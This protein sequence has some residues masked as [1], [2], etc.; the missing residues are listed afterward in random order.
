MNA[1]LSGGSSGLGSS[2][3]DGDPE[4]WARSWLLGWLKGP[5]HQLSTQ[6]DL[7]PEPRRDP[8]RTHV[9]GMARSQQ[10]TACAHCGSSIDNAAASISGSVMGDEE[11]EAWFYCSDCAAYTRVRGRDR[12]H[13]EEN[14]RPGEPFSLERGDHQVGIIRR[15]ERPWD[16]SC[17]CDAH[18]EY[19]GGW[20]D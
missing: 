3:I 17:R 20:L 11:T 6:R 19:F 16:K 15:C 5:L 2:P 9:G 13:G 4:G 14:V 10:V 1:S 12:F 7:G 8:V 18:R